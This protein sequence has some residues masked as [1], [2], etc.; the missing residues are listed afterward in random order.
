MI[1]AIITS[2]TRIKLLYKFFIN[3]NTQGYLRNLESEFKDNCNGIRIE[4]NRLE[5]ARLLKSTYDGYKKMYFANTSHP[6]YNDIHNIIL[7][8]VGIDQLIQM[9]ISRIGN[10]KSAYLTGSFAEGRESK[11]IDLALIGED[12][13]QEYIFK[14]IKKVE[15]EISRKVRIITLS[16]YQIKE[17]FKNTPIFL[18]WENDGVYKS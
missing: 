7:K 2:K 3:H 18:L 4:L 14:L 6:L 12:L 17:Y 9:V 13:N 11:I 8:S 5:K 15:H 10:L 1:E 16:E